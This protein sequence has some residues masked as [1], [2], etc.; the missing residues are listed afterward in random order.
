[1]PA[2]LGMCPQGGADSGRRTCVQHPLHDR[3]LPQQPIEFDQHEFRQGHVVATV[4][5]PNE[6]G[7]R[8]VVGVVRHDEGEQDIRVEGDH[9]RLR[10][11]G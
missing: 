4:E 3:R 1:M 6:R 11:F 7:H 10:A 2:P 5:P 9:P 8:G